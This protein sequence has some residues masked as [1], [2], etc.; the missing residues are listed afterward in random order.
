MRLDSARA[1]KAQLLEEVTSV[2]AADLSAGGV[3]SMTARPIEDVDPVARTLALGITRPTPGDYRLAL[4]VQRRGLENT[5]Q[6][7]GIRRKARGEVDV[8]YVGHV[9]KQALPWEQTRKRPLL[10]GL[11]VGHYKI[12]A[13]TLG[14]FVRLRKGGA[15]RV[16]SNNH[17]L[18]DENRGKAGDAILQ[19][20]A[21]DG[22]KSPRDRI[23]TLDGFVKLKTA[24][25]N[26]VDCAL[27]ALDPKVTFKAAA[28]TGV[29][30]L[31][32]ATAPPAEEIDLVEKIGRTTGHTRG[33]VTAFELDNLVVGYDQGN[34]RFDGQIE[35]E[36]ASTE[37]FSQGGDSGSLIFTSL[38][39]EAAALLFA[40]GDQGGS[41]G[42]GLTFANP[43]AAV[44]DQLKA[45]LA[46]K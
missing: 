2:P 29:G 14:A 6:V 12:T 16:L 45:N 44:F 25:V 17:V 4:R 26:L 15:L 42:K 39:H 18:A 35:I 8:R 1:L 38:G 5:R 36:G 41:N 28:L 13:G 3:W 37:P 46:T 9:V 11:S 30:T 34:L 7:D 19:P 33:R 21:Y 32:S 31:S 43:I 23:G 22:G 40:G 10:I 24:G 20:G 27:A